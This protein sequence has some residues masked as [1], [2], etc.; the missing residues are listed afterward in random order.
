M[1]VAASVLMLAGAQAQTSD[2]PAEPAGSTSPATEASPPVAQ[3][4]AEPSEAE[5]LAYAKTF[6]E[7]LQRRTGAISVAGDKATITVP[8]THYFLGPEDSRR[9]IVDVWGNPPEAAEH[10]EGMIFPADGNPAV[11]SWGAVVE[12]STDGYVSDEDASTIDYSALLRDL[13]SGTNEANSA[14]RQAGY[15]GITLL[16]WAEN[17]HYDA[18]AHKLYWGKRLLIEGADAETLNYDV[19]VLGR[20]GFLQMSFISGMS[21]LAS[22][23]A[24]MPAVLSM[25]EF[26]S[27]FRYADYQPGV[28]KKA[29]YGIAGLIA[30]GA[31][32]AVAKKAGLLAIVLAFGK[33]FIVLIGVG[34]AA[35]FGALR[36]VLGAKPKMEVDPPAASS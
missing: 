22:I 12:Y 21:E 18:N 31:A 6:F 14:R 3:A 24:S 15:P 30:G 33:K 10:I 8:E 26:N 1:A 4:G 7:S 19:R 9:V 17:P 34:I 20:E 25:S 16:G 35:A 28:D 29:A 2:A 27:G 23:R 11:G 13:Q 32:L 5:Y 36:R